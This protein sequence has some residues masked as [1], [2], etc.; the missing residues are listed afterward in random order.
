MLFKKNDVSFTLFHVLH[1][2]YKG[3]NSPLHEVLSVDIAF[4]GGANS[5]VHASAFGAFTAQP[6]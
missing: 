5:P 6:M 4:N 2:F 3:V 1:S